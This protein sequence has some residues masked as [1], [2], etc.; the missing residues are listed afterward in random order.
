MA[1]EGEHVLKNQLVLDEFVEYIKYEPMESRFLEIFNEDKLVTGKNM[2]ISNGETM[3]GGTLKC[4][5]VKVSNNMKTVKG[6]TVE[7]CENVECKNMGGEP[8]NEF[9]EI[10]EVEYH[11]YQFNE[12]NNPLVKKRMLVYENAEKYKPNKTKPIEQQHNK[13]SK[14]I[15]CKWH[16]NLSNPEVGGF[17]HITLTHL[18]YNHTIDAKNI[19]FATAF[20]KFDESIMNEIEHAYS[21]IVLYNNTSRTNK[22]NFPLSLF[23]F[24]DNYDKS[25]LDIQTFL[26]DETQESYEWILQQTLDATNIEPQVIMTD[27]DQAMDAVDSIYSKPFVSTSLQKYQNENNMCNLIPKHHYNIQKAQVQH[28]LQKKM[29]YGHL[30]ASVSIELSDGHI[31]DV[32]SI[33]DPVVCKE[34]GRLP[35]KRLKASNEDKSKGS[36]KKTQIVSSDDVDSDHSEIKANRLTNI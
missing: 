30:M 11:K 24:V 22:Y 19:R 13:G 3:K 23:I 6:K 4:K 28:C 25:Q 21:D 36:N 17:V 34:K 20:R 5:N 27:M 1:V 2:K 18:V 32:D 8:V 29:D 9:I 16:I 33:K 31:Y 7:K 26:S 12:S 15:N 35:S 10:N 14:K